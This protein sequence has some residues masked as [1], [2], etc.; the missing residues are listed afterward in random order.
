MIT[1]IYRLHSMRGRNVVKWPD[2][3]NEIELL[4]KVGFNI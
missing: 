2:S 1:Y 3:L 4:I